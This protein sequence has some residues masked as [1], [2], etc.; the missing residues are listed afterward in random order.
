MKHY[1]DQ[2]NDAQRLVIERTLAAYARGEKPGRIV[3]DHGLEVT[4]ME[5]EDMRQRVRA[6][7]REA[8]EDLAEKSRDWVEAHEARVAKYRAQVADGTIR[9]KDF[10]AWM[11]GQLFQ[12]RQWKLKQIQAAERLA[13]ADQDAVAMINGRKA[14]IFAENANWTGYRLEG[15]GKVDIGFGVY[16]QNTVARL[17]RDRPRLLPMPRIDEAK[18]G[19]WYNRIL[20]NSITQAILQGESL[21]Q[22]V[23]R[24]Y[25]RASDVGFKAIYR[26]MVTAFTGAQNAGRLEGMR[27]AQELGIRVKKR[28]MSLLD[29]RVRDA[30]IALDGQTAEVE[31]PFE[32]LLGPILYPG[33]PDADPANVYNCRCTLGYEYPDDPYPHGI[34]RREV[35][36]DPVE[37]G[38]D[39]GPVTYEE[40][41]RRKAEGLRNAVG[42]A[43]IKA[44]H[45]DLTGE[46]GSILQ[47]V[48]RRGG[49]DRAYYGED[50]R[51]Q[52]QISNNDHGHATERGFGRHGE[53]AHDFQW[54]G[55][56]PS[57]GRARELTEEER[58]ENDDILQGRQH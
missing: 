7:Y 54:D 18:T 17:I 26:H 13:R 11:R 34:P 39:A 48:N 15:G 1:G 49:V 19:E 4:A 3:P 25:R 52:K 53:H 6:V 51:M 20:T 35:I 32:S 43:I 8:R 36:E 56:S 12:Q 46:P 5:I 21:D 37:V 44:E 28:W 47:V 9:Q 14:N 2:Y 33:D 41:V 24:M 57:R 30:H 27:Q 31:D 55:D 23:L 58:R 45:F 16:D 22:M 29:D 40:W 38:A 10:D 42:K 50:G